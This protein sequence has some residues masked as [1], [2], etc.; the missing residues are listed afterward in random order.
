MPKE[1]GA[2][3]LFKFFFA[4]DLSIFLLLRL[5][6]RPQFPA[7]CE[8][9]F[10][11]VVPWS[12]SSIITWIYL[13]DEKWGAPNSFL[14]LDGCKLGSKHIGWL[15]GSAM[16]VDLIVCEKCGERWNIDFS[17]FIPVT[18]GHLHFLAHILSPLI[19]AKTGEIELVCLP[20]KVVFSAI[21]GFSNRS[22]FGLCNSLVRL[23]L[24]VVS[25]GDSKCAS[26]VRWGV[27]E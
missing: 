3:S 9:C 13:M 5:S 15:H 1:W 21:H 16:C 12:L 4:C 20:L 7:S 22:R 19:M 17:T 2:Y 24:Q 23:I 6:L 27:R 18:V 26:C 8:E 11:A 10:P 14:Y 25:N